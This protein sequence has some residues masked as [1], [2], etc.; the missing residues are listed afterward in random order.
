[1]GWFLSLNRYVLLSVSIVLRQKAG[2]MADIIN[3]PQPLTINFKDLQVIQAAFFL[4][5]TLQDS[6]G[7]DN[8]YGMA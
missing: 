4:N 2:D 7:L 1:M 5:P 3:E 8:A 6:V